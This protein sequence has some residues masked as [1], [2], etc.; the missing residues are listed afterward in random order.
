M[1][2]VEIGSFLRLVPWDEQLWTETQSQGDREG[3]G[4][5]LELFSCASQG[6]FLAEGLLVHLHTSKFPSGK[7][8][9][10]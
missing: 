8:E 6:M 4:G 7:K 5:G 1:P 9:E 10:D 3:G 2:V